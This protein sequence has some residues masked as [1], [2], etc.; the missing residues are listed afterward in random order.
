[1]GMRERVLVFY[2]ILTHCAMYIPYIIILPT[3]TNYYTLIVLWI[4]RT[5][6]YMIGN[7][8]VRIYLWILST[9]WCT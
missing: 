8:I 2:R 1:M 9:R 5:S 7:T 6:M 4:A 3:S